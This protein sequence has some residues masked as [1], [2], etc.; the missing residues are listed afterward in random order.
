[1]LTA[2]RCLYF[3]HK[4]EMKIMNVIIAGVTAEGKTTIAKMF[5]EFLIE[6]GI[7]KVEV[8]DDD[9]EV[10]GQIVSKEAY[11]ALIEKQPRILIQ[12]MQV[13]SISS[14][15]GADGKPIRMNQIPT[16]LDLKI[17]KS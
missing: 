8:L 9:A 14:V 6:M 15:V 16:K 17:A 7:K 5:A 13:Q 12:T 4:K 2:I 10:V 1:M 3:H 11:Y